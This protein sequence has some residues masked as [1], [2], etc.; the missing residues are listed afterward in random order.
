MGATHAL[1]VQV[2]WDAPGSPCH[3]LLSEPRPCGPFPACKNIEHIIR[4][5][6]AVAGGSLMNMR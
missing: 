4:Y 3:C 5:G 1:L 6:D 2:G